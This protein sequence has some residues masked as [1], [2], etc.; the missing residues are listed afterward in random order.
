MADAYFWLV[1]QIGMILCFQGLV[2][3]KYEAVGWDYKGYSKGW[4]SQGER[5]KGRGIRFQ[6]IFLKYIPNDCIIYLHIHKHDKQD[7]LPPS[8][9]LPS[10]SGLLDW[11]SRMTRKLQ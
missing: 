11:L 9:Q 6:S 4:R 3:I 2:S 8:I 7:Y 10:N 5:I 1:V